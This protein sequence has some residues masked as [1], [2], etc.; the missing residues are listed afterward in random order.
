MTGTLKVKS[1][2]IS[3]PEPKNGR[4]PYFELSEKY[5]IKVDFRPFIHVES[6]TPKEF[7]RNKVR[8][9]DHSAVIFTS[10]TGIET[11]FKMIKEMRTEVSPELKYFC[12]TEAVALYLQKFTTFRKR[13]VF[14]PK[15]RD[16]TLKQLIAKHKKETY[17]FTRSDVCKN[18]LPDFMRDN[19]ISFSE[20]ILY[21]TVTS[22]LSDLKE[23]NYDVIAFF[24]PSGINSLFDNFPDFEQNGT[25]IAAFGKATGSAVKSRGLRLDIEAPAP[26]APSMHTALEQFIKQNNKV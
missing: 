18:D 5:K 11:F 9:A 1:I 23:V 10:R 22:D 12:T 8:I 20:A 7:R 21:H 24:S 15:S 17:L 4:S 3:Q 14:Y 19:K 6:V 13:K 16:K 26:G 25:R 2:L